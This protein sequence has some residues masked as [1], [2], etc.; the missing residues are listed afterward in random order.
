[1][2]GFISHVCVRERE[3]ERENGSAGTQGRRKARRKGG[4]VRGGG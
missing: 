3:R 1:M 2:H 4:R